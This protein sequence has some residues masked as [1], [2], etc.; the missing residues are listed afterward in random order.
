[1]TSLVAYARALSDCSMFHH[2]TCKYLLFLVAYNVPHAFHHG[3]ALYRTVLVFLGWA[4]S[5]QMWTGF[6]FEVCDS[7]P[8]MG[9]VYVDCA[10]FLFCP[11]LVPDYRNKEMLLT[12]MD[13]PLHLSLPYTLG[14]NPH[15]NL[16]RT[17]FCRFLKRNKS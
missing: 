15:P 14:S 3:W 4:F 8:V 13:F 2:L 1:V 12:T 17:S 11:V 5:V 6:V 10:S 9:S 7:Y 16:I